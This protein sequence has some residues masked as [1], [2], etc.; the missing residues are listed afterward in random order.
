MSI[1][2]GKILWKTV[3]A[4]GVGLAGYDAYKRGEWQAKTNHKLAS[5]DLM[6]RVH[7]NSQ[8][9]ENHSAVRSGIKNS[10]NR[11]FLDTS[12]I[13][14]VFRAIGGF[15][16]GVVSSL[17][18]N[19]VPL[20][21]ATGALTLKRGAKWCVLGLGLYAAKFLVTDIFGIGKPNYLPDQV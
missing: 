11:K 10:F 16:S 5:A 13:T 12:N 2:L 7:M 4:A 3:G 9:L 20:A 21:L 17:A 18:D 6:T 1:I 19:V 15:C 14:P 8:T